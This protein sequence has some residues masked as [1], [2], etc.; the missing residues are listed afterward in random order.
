MNY[1]FV[2][3]FISLTFFISPETQEATSPPKVEISVPGAGDGVSWGAQVRYSIHVS[4]P[5][6]GD[7]KYGEISANEVLLRIEYLPVK[8]EADLKE[9]LGRL[10]S[11]EEPK[12]LSLIKRSTCFGCHSDKVRVSG[13]SFAEIAG[14][15]EATPANVN[16]LATHIMKG[17]SGN[18]GSMQMPPHPDFTPEQAKEI[19]DFILEE[20]GNKY[21]WVYPGLE[22]GFRVIEKPADGS[23]GVYV[24]TASYTSKANVRGQQSVVLK[25]K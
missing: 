4:D 6:D 8:N 21:R 13:P 14:K 12:G 19:V 22:G 16:V 20:G 17:T 15:Y 2:L 9:D 3:F 25:V 18:W 23:E 5:V 11:A 7:S 24:L 10:R 1:L